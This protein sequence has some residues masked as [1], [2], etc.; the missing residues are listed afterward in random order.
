MLVTFS[1]FRAKLSFSFRISRQKKI[2]KKSLCLS[3]SKRSQYIGSHFARE[4]VAI[5][6]H[7]VEYLL[8]T[9]CVNSSTCIW[10]HFGI[11]TFCSIARNWNLRCPPNI[12]FSIFARGTYLFHSFLA[13]NHWIIL[14]RC[15]PCELL[16][17]TL[18]FL[19]RTNTCSVTPKVIIQ[20][21]GVVTYYN[22]FFKIPWFWRINTSRNNYSN[23]PK[24][25]VYNHDCLHVLKYVRWH[26]MMK[27]KW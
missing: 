10:T 17:P 9:H 19:P 13:A 23:L 18:A 21:T 26:D 24:Q 5:F 3:E 8:I 12:T 7:C 16:F 22:T 27:R 6:E 2:R 1:I 20:S 14:A 4:N 25:Q 11:G 15:E